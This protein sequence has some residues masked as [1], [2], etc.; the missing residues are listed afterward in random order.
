MS[1]KDDISLESA[2]PGFLGLQPR[3]IKNKEHTPDE[4]ETWKT[5]AKDTRLT[6]RER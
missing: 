1:A 5:D 2:F 4:P 6:R 3:A